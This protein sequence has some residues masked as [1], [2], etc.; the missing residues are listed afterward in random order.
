MKRKVYYITYCNGDDFQ[1][2]I[3]HYSEPFKNKADAIAFED[4]INKYEAMNSRLEL[5][6][7]IFECNEWR[8]DF[9]LGDTWLKI[10]N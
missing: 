8:P 6:N 4:K 5:H 9:D 1:K 3:I 10:I 7:E 2:G